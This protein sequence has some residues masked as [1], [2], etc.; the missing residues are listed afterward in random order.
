MRARRWATVLVSGDLFAELW[1]SGERHYRIENGIPDDAKV[2][3]VFFNSLRNVWEI[4]LESPSFDEVPEG[5]I[6]PELPPV[7][8]TTL[9][10]RRA[11]Q[12]VGGAK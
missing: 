2:M 10:C 7:E 8:T 5:V 6:P 3:G 9:D 12:L 11:A 1:K 4:A